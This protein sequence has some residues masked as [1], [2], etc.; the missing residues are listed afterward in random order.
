M[1]HERTYTWGVSLEL[2]VA[3]QGLNGLDLLAKIKTRGGVLKVE[4]A[5]RV[6]R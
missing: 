3:G 1:T 5:A 4:R 2:S 6:S